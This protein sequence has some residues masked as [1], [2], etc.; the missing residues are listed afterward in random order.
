MRGGDIS[1]LASPPANEPALDTGT[2][3]VQRADRLAVWSVSKWWIR[4][5]PQSE[6]ALRKFASKGH[7]AGSQSA[8]GSRQAD[9]S[10]GRSRT[11]AAT[12]HADGLAC[13][14]AP[15]GDG[16]RD[17]RLASH[18]D[19]PIR[20][21]RYSIGALCSRDGGRDAS[22]EFHR[23]A[24]RAQTSTLCCTQPAHNHGAEGSGGHDAGTWH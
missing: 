19:G 9:S 6:T 4:E 18:S 2:E 1:P 17:E 16:C 14:G 21:Q 22:T 12:E 24:C 8:G 11:P 10:P 7:A 13:M 15:L 23:R 20:R 5:P 3:N